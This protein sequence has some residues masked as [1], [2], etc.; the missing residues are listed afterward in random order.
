MKASGWKGNIGTVDVQI[1]QRLETR[2]GQSLPPD[3]V[4]MLM[5]Y[6]GGRPDRNWLLIPGKVDTVVREFYGFGS[7]SSLDLSLLP[8]IQYV[9]LPA[10][11]IPIGADMGGNHI[12]LNIGNE[13]YGSVYWKDHEA[14]NPQ[15]C[16]IK[17]ADSFNDFLSA[18]QLLI[19]EEGEEIEKLA[20]SGLPTDLENYLARG[21]QIDVKSLA[22]RTL[23]QE[24]A[25]FGNLPLLKLCAEHGGSIQGSIHM[26][27]LNGHLTVVQYLLE[28]LKVDVNEKDAKG[29]S[30]RM[31]AFL[32]PEIQAYLERL[33]G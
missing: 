8:D 5:R 24:F 33:G 27:A 28:E 13:E 16:L 15:S 20:E 1:I 29:R 14:L 30:P 23:C 10:N 19:P 21:N 26:A 6:N 4:V 2:L 17:V 12:A 7:L 25:R 3:Y 32:N 31:C 9:E 22:G 11:I 18:L